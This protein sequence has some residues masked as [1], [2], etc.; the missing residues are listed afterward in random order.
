MEILEVTP[1]DDVNLVPCL[2]EHYLAV[3][4]SIKVWHTTENGIPV[5]RVSFQKAFAVLFQR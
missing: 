3:V 2:E 5:L 1:K 4:V